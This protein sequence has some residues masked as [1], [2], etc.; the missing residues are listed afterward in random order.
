MTPVFVS[1]IAFPACAALF[2]FR[3]VGAT[4]DGEGEIDM[5]QRRR[6]AFSDQRLPIARKLGPGVKLHTDAREVSR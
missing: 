6:A 3:D 2:P 1:C 5:E 4:T